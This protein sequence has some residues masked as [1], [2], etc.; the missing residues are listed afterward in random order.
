MEREDK[1]RVFSISHQKKM[2]PKKTQ[3]YLKKQPDFN[4]RFQHRIVMALMMFES[5]DSKIYSFD[6]KQKQQYLWFFFHLSFENRCSKQKKSIKRATRSKSRTKLS[7]PD[8]KA[9]KQFG[10]GK[11]HVFFIRSK[12][13]EGDFVFFS[14]FW[15]YLKFTWQSGKTK[16]WIKIETIDLRTSS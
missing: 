11:D 16:I 15:W 10:G 5:K 9:E 4:E 14:S 3:K 2:K 12:Q 6:S 13:F 8:R 1:L 7:K